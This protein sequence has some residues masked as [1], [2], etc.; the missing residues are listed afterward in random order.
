MVN[1]KRHKRLVSRIKFLETNILPNIK[2]NGNYT[3]KESDLIRSYVLLSHAEIESFFED[4]SQAKAKKALTEWKSNRTKS[5]CLLAIM[6]F[7]TDEVGWD[8]T[9]KEKKEKFDYRVIRVVAHYIEKLSNN[10]G[11]KAENIKN[12]LLPIGIEESQIDDT[13]LN[14][15]ESFGAQRGLIAHS[16]I[17]VQQ[18]IDLATNKNNI[19][20]NILPTIKELDLLIKALK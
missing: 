14:T 1:S 17:S 3:K 18:Q 15:M 19:N 16:T 9:K 10:H 7:C 4:I 11:I 20:N 5:N 12:I 6:S 13:W 2:I 8:K